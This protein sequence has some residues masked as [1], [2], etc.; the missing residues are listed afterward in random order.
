MLNGF[1]KRSSARPRRGRWRRLSGGCASTTNGLR[2]SPNKQGKTWGR[3]RTQSEDP[4][5]QIATERREVHREV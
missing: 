2:A 3:G 5:P 4:P 1:V